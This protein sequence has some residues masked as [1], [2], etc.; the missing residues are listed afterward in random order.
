MLRPDTLPFDLTCFTQ[1]A[2]NQV[3][4]ELKK[5]QATLLLL[6]LQNSTRSDKFHDP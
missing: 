5:K 3:L 1:P 4:P 6:L 2:V